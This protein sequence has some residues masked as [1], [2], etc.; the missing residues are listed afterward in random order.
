M[1]SVLTS[2]FLLAGFGACATT[3]T[4]NV[5]REEPASSSVQLDLVPHTDAT[6]TFPAVVAARLPTADRL[7]SQI[8]YELGESASVDVRLCVAAGGSVESIAITR[9][10][11]LPAFDDSVIADASSWQFAAMPGPATLRTCEQATITYRP[12]S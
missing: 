2:V 6:R 11:N 8:R 10:S 9:G 1:K 12:H 7:A 3:S 4:L 5:E